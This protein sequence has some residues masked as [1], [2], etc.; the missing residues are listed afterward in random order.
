MPREIIHKRGPVRTLVGSNIYSQ[1]VW[2]NQTATRH[3]VCQWQ[4]VDGYKVRDYQ[5]RM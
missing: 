3:L 1:Q 4:L 2:S 5:K